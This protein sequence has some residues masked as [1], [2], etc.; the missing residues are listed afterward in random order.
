MD[1]RFSFYLYQSQNGIWRRGRLWRVDGGWCWIFCFFNIYKQAKV[2]YFLFP[3][4]SS[5]LRI[6]EEYRM[7]EWKSYFFPCFFFRPKKRMNEWFLNFSVEKNK[8]TKQ[9]TKIRKKNIRNF[10]IKKGTSSKSDWM[11]DELFLGNWK[12]ICFFFPASRKHYFRI[13]MN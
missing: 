2:P 5:F 7:N 10:Y 11:T 3:R 6:Y 4:K 8:K 13:W 1:Y 9:H 12:K